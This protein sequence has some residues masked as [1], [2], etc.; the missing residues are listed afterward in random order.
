MIVCKAQVSFA[1]L[2]FPHERLRY[3]VFL[4][5]LPT[6]LFSVRLH[7]SFSYFFVPLTVTILLWGMPLHKGIQ[8]VVQSVVQTVVQSVV[9]GTKV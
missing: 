3:F 4:F 5:S 6:F 9:G 7:L 8:T 2:A 1:V